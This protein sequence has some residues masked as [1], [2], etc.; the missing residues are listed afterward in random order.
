M[1]TKIDRDSRRVNAVGL[2]SIRDGISTI[3]RPPLQSSTGVGFLE[4]RFVRLELSFSPR[5]APRLL[6]LDC[7]IRQRRCISN[8]MDDSSGM[9]QTDDDYVNIVILLCYGSVTILI[10]S[11]LPW[12][13]TPGSHPHPEISY[14]RSDDLIVETAQ[15]PV[16]ASVTAHSPPPSQPPIWYEKYEISQDSFF[17]RQPTSV[18][19]FSLYVYPRPLP[20]SE[21]DFA[22]W[23]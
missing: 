17:N 1:R 6:G 20:P 15:N 10:S 14:Q 13:P 11:S 7:Q 22:A 23:C 9:L 21:N 8:A 18:A 2:A 4:P 12:T 16:I 3:T 19:V 5:C